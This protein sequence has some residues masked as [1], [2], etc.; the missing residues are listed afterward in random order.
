MTHIKKYH[1]SSLVCL[2]LLRTYIVKSK[3]HIYSTRLDFKACETIGD[4][5]FQYQIIL[6]I[7]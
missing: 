7:P 3:Y 1:V 2:V 6:I 4:R 5:L